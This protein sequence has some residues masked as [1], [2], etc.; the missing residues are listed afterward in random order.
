MTG[1]QTCALPISALAALS[2]SDVSVLAASRDVGAA[3]VDITPTFPVR[4]SGYGNRRTVHEAVEGKIFAKALAIGSDADGPAVLLTVD[5]CGVPASVRSA[6]FQRLAPKTK[7]TD[8]R[9]AICSSHTHSAPMLNGVLPTIFGVP[10]PP[11]E[12]ATTPAQAQAIAEKFGTAVMVKAQVHA[13][14]RGK[15]GGVKFCKK[16]GRAHV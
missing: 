4:L 11:G 5:N 14:G 15:A 2:F 1:V 10:I 16:I 12:V 8:E 13:G 7:L 6:V 3:R 9:F